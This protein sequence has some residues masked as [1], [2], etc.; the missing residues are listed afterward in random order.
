MKDFNWL[1]L[2][3]RMLSYILISFELEVV[4]LTQRLASVLWIVIGTYQ[5]ILLSLILVV[6]V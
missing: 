1:I 5:L 6:A 4:V 3:D 2:I